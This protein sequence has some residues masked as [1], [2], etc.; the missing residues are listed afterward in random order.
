M[1]DVYVY[2]RVASADAAQLRPRVLAMQAA[3]AS[4]HGVST[5]LKRRPEEKDEQQTWMEVYC[6]VP[7][8]FISALAH[9][10]EQLSSHAI[11]ERHVEI[12]V[13][14]PECA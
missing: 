3:L 8:H 4:S 5:A 11:G 9:A 13:D 1:T 14:I 6:S 10:S 7:E 12:F 2:Y